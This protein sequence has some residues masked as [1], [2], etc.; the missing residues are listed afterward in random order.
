MFLKTG[1]PFQIS[2]QYI[3]IFFFFLSIT[4]TSLKNNDNRLL[5]LS[6]RIRVAKNIFETNGTIIP[7]HLPLIEL[8]EDSTIRYESRGEQKS[9]LPQRDKSNFSDEVRIIPRASS[10]IHWRR[11]NREYIV[12]HEF[13]HRFLKGRFHNRHPLL[14]QRVSTLKY[15]RYKSPTV[16]PCR[17]CIIKCR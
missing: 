10:Y 6:P 7:L 13:F 8:F 17:D 1:F 15:R 4:I 5:F 11:L 12:F 2:F 9:R 3:Y 14:P 16:R